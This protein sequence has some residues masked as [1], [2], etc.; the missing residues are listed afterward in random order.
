MPSVEGEGGTIAACIDLSN[1][2]FISTSCVKLPASPQPTEGLRRPYC[3][4]GWRSDALSREAGNSAL[5]RRADSRLGWKGWLLLV[6]TEL[7]AGE[8]ALGGI[9]ELPEE[10]APGRWCFSSNFSRRKRGSRAALRVGRSQGVS[11]ARARDGGQA[12]GPPG[13]PLV[14]PGA[15]AG[16]APRLLSSAE[17][18]PCGRCSPSV[19]SKVLRPGGP[20]P[21]PHSTSRN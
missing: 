14:L 10:A 19:S 11:A 13:N 8:E 20:W 9:W 5:M 18:L 4:P 21:C 17:H 7:R 15:T 3:V 6:E 16:A 2:I 12:S 1:S